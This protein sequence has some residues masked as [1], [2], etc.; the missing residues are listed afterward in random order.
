VKTLPHVGDLFLSSNKKKKNPLQIKN[1]DAYYLY[2]Y[3]FEF[4]EKNSYDRD[5]EPLGIFIGNGY[6]DGNFNIYKGKDAYLIMSYDLQDK[7]MSK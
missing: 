3:N 4:F 2:N 7:L 5:E 6:G 1:Y